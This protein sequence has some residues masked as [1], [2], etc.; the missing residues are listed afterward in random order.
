LL[1]SYRGVVAGSRTAPAT[2]NARRR[3]SSFPG[4]RVFPG[5]ET[6][7]LDALRLGGAG[8]ISATANVN[9]GGDGQLIRGL[10]SAD[11]DA[12]QRALTAVRARDP[13]IPAGLREQGDPRADATTTTGWNVV[14]PPLVPLVTGARPELFASL[15]ALQ[16]HAGQPVPAR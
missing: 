16:F 15:D 13:E 9:V 11:A 7:L 5:A 10:E 8:C 14:R 2:G 3:F 1:K 6:Y 4:L 12:M